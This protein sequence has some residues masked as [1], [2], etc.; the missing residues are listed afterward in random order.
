MS[1]KGTTKPADHVTNDHAFKLL[2]M[3]TH[4]ELAL[5]LSNFETKQYYDIELLVQAAN[6]TKMMHN[7]YVYLNVDFTVIVS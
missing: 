3:N 5:K 1:T 4:G 7:F 2:G 6:R